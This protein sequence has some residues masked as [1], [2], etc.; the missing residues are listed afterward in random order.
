MRSVRRDCWPIVRT[1]I[2]AARVL[3]EE[4]L[5]IRRQLGDR[6]GIGVA[7]GNLGMVALG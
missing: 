6:K 5:A 4:S 7:A 2:V 1:T 3:L